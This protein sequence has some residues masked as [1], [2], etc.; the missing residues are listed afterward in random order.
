MHQD[1]GDLFPHHH[2]SCPRCPDW[3]SQ[4]IVHASAT[5]IPLE[6]QV[7]L[8]EHMMGHAEGIP[9]VDQTEV[10]EWNAMTH[11]QRIEQ[12]RITNIAF[13]GQPEAPFIRGTAN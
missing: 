1:H 11:E 3:Q 13:H 5:V 4:R 7:E 10:D 9:G 6:M 2:M 12:M 8:A